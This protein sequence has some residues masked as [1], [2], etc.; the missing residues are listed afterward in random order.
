M[1]INECIEPVLQSFSKKEKETGLM[2]RIDIDPSTKNY[3]ITTDTSKVREIVRRLLENAFDQNQPR[4]RRRRRFGIDSSVKN[5]YNS[6][7]YINI[8]IV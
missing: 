2:L 1:T 6:I 8:I 3:P 4:R 7:R 5:D